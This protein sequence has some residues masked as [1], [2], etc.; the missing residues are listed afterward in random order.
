MNNFY[1]NGSFSSIRFQ[2]LYLFQKYIIIAFFIIVFI[3]NIKEANIGISPTEIEGDDN[4]IIKN[5]KYY[6]KLEIVEKFNTF[7]KLCKQGKMIDKIKYPLLKAPKI[8]I[9]IPVYNGGQYLNYSLRTIQ[10]QNLKEIEILIIDDCSTDDSIINIEKFMEEDPRIRLIQNFR[11]RK[12]LYSKSIAALNCNGEFILELD[13][14]DMFIREDLFEII[15]NES[16]RSNL[17]LLQFRDFFK[18]QDFFKRRTQINDFNL[19]WIRNNY[20]YYMEGHELKETLFKN[21][22]N[23]LLWGLLISSKI[24]KKAIYYIWEF[25]INYQIIYN[26]DYISTTMIVLLT[27]N[28]KYLNMFG[29]LHLK[30]KKS[31]SFNCINKTEFHLSNIIFPSFLYEYHIKNNIKDIHMVFNYMNIALNINLQK[32]ASNL[33]PNIFEFNIRNIFNNLIYIYI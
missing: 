6:L 8:S 33:F 26:E 10:N 12:I 32:R 24:Y 31:S 15:Y 22:N 23:Y 20:T 2:Y 3:A 16:K 7:L 11:H 14:D 1:F 4:Y 29:I 9:I 27:H 19:H 13:Q 5:N 30:H 28:Y 18:E 17:D 21:K 25:I